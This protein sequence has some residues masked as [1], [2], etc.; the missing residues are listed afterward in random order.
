ML[1]GFRNILI[2]ELKELIR[3]PKILIGIII[4]PIVMFPALG[5]VIGYAEQTAIEQAQ[6]TSLLVLNNDGGNWSETLISYLQAAGAET[7]IVNNL[8]PQQLVSQGLLAENNATQFVEIPQGFTE[9]LTKHFAGDTNIMAVVNVYGVFNI[10]GIFS[11]IG[12]SGITSLVYS[13]NRYIAPDVL[14]TTQSS[15]IKGEIEQNIDPATLS[16]L[17]ISQSII[18][19]IT[20]M[21]LLTYSMQIAATSV[22]M[23]KEE[24]T[25]ETLLT[26][27]VDRF[28]ILMGKLS[29][30]ALV[31]GLGAITYLVG[32]S[33]LFGSITS[34]VSTTGAS[35]DLAALGLA[36]TALGYILLGITLF[37]TLLAGLALAVII[38][39][40][41]EDVRGATALVGYMYPLIF[42]P[43]F[44]LIYIDINVLPLPIKAVLFAIPFSQ[45][46]IASKAVIAGDYLTTILGIIY[47]A[48]FTLVVMYIA[49]RLFATEKILT[50]KLRFGRRGSKKTAEQQE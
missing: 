20:I 11:N 6:K 16:S 1:R 28:S 27:P 49:S 47:V 50:A 32:Y 9:N 15:I 41:A 8:T 26:M 37:V 40:F 31:A 39:A 43:S 42:I 12:S 24:K 46:V 10:G 2:K 33:Y 30:S 17:L 19:P 23:E 34:G 25:L 29:S 21:I 45:P 36:P 5:L 44:A 38:S 35:L 4:I 13:F 48:A 22:A 14:Q 3:D 18:L 7:T